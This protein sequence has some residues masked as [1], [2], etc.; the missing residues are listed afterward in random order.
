[1]WTQPLVAIHL[2]AAGCA[3]TAF[4]I[5]RTWSD[6]E[7][8]RIGGAA[9]L[10][11]LVVGSAAIVL[12]D[13]AFNVMRTISANDG[14]LAFGYSSILSVALVCGAIG[15]WNLRQYW[16]GKA[17]Y[18][19]AVL[20]SAVIASVGLAV[21]QFALL[22]LSGDGSIYAIKKHMFIIFTL[23]MMN[24]VR[25]VAS[26]VSI[27]TKDLSPGLVAP[28]LAGCAS[29]FVLA[30]Y[31]TPVGPVVEAL[32]YANKAAKYQLANLKPGNTVFDDQELP[33]MGNV[34]VSL[35]ALQHPF[36]VRSVSWQGRCVN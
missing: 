2:L 19:D 11:V 13:P 28:I 25:V 24:A 23:G 9:N 35:T 20:G 36:G 27:N 1:M 7:V 6:K 4:Q 18:V 14:Y 21:L 22:K 15:I 33:V 10:A 12:T 8:S 29:F 34:P 17:E 16:Y 3:L 32:A 26:Y 31:N 30:G 5:L